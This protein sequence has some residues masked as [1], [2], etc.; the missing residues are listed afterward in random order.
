M[1]GT[2]LKYEG[3]SLYYWCV[4]CDFV[5]EASEWT[6]FCKDDCFDRLDRRILGRDSRFRHVSLTTSEVKR[7]THHVKISP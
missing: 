7:I 6:S 5:L 1:P 2:F 4:R 3:R